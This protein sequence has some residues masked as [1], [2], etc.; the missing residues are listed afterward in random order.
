MTKKTQKQN[1]YLNWQS[2]LAEDNL[3][4]ALQEQREDELKGFIDIK[5]DVE[6]ILESLFQHQTLKVEHKIND[7]KYKVDNRIKELEKER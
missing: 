4:K 2:K 7:L 3:N 5:E 1:N 6:N